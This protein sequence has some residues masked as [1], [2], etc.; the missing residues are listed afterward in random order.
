[1]A[2]L[3][4]ELVFRITFAVMYGIFGF[5][6]IYYRRKATKSRR[7]QSDEP[8]KTDPIRNWAYI[9]ITISI[10]GMIIAYILY[11]FIP[12]WI[13][14]FPLPFPIILRWFGVP[15]GL[16]AVPLLIWTHRTLGRWWSAELEIQNQHRIIKTGPYARIRHPM[17]TAF[18]IFTLGTIL[19]AAN[20]F[21]TIFGLL[22]ILFLSPISKIEEQMLLNEFGDQ[23]HDYMKHTGRFI[24][25]I[26]QPQQLVEDTSSHQDKTDND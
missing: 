23:Y 1:V 22:V 25:Q 19:L 17:Y 12:P 10:L 16:S 2:G 14:W 21:V 26:R 9:A 15:L 18:I 3:I 4:E 6:R 5:T 13:P 7:K 8:R 24:P 20:L 11:L